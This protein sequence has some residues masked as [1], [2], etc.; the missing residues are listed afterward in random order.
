[1]MEFITGFAFGFFTGAFIIAVLVTWYCV[2][3]AEGM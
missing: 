2:Y 1:M 3:Q